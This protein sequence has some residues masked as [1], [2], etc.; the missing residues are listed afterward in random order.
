MEELNLKVI[1]WIIVGIVYIITKMRGKPAT[2]P[3]A[4]PEPGHEP[5]KGLTFEELLREIQGTKQP[6]PPIQPTPAM[7]EAEDIE[8]EKP[9]EQVDY[10]Y[11]DHDKIYETYEKAKQE[12]FL[13]PSMEETMKLENTIVRFGQ[14]K[15]YVVEEQLSLAAQYARDL[16]NPDDFKKALILSEI[17]NRRF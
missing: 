3:S 6:A 2:P 11:R 1:F 17:L 12:A 4:P 16:R 10:S 14:F 8:E 5:E 13:R 7:D 9:I 15:N